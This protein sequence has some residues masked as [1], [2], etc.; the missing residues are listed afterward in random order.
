M[1]KE[2]KKNIEGSTNCLNLD[3]QW[4]KSPANLDFY[5]S[6]SQSPSSFTLNIPD[7]FHFNL[8]CFPF[9][10]PT[11]LPTVFDYLEQTIN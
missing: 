8:F 2:K 4:L 6:E 3:S 5:F 9:M 11:L 1:K 10:G 7:S